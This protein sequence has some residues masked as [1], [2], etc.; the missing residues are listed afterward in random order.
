MALERRSFYL[1]AGKCLPVT[2]TEIVAKFRKPPSLI[3][4]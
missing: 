3:P 4:D 1:R 2:C